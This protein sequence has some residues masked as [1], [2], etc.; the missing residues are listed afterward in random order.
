MANDSYSFAPDLWSSLESVTC[1]RRYEPGAMVFEQGQSAEGIYMIQKGQVR[2]WMPRDSEPE[3]LVQAVGSGTMLA[4][5]EALSDGAHKL[6]AQALQQTEIGFVPRET[7]AEF[8]RDHHQLCLQVVRMLS[9]DLHALYHKFQ[10]L[11]VARS[12]A[13]RWEPN[14]GVQ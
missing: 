14:R 10:G 8:L 13:R 5:S 11:N 1:L 4:L 7:L 9:E 6:S 3:A 2:V 12:R